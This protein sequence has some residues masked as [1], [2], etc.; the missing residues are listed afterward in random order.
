MH[1]EGSAVE[2]NFLN[3]KY[4]G[5]LFEPSVPEQKIISHKKIT[6]YVKGAGCPA[7]KLILATDQNAAHLQYMTHSVFLFV[8]YAF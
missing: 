8:N 3:F 2:I 1:R 6:D 7:C 5:I 4:E